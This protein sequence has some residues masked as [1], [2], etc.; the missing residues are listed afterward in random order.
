MLLNL[1]LGRQR[2]EEHKFRASLELYNEF[3][4]ILSSLTRYHLKIMNKEK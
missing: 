3:E 4:V 2:K 1:E